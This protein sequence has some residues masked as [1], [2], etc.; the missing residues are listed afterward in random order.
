[1]DSQ[2]AGLL[3]PDLK[4]DQVRTAV[5]AD[6][7]VDIVADL[8]RA[9]TRVDPHYREVTLSCAAAAETLLAAVKA[10]GYDGVLTPLPEPHARTVIARSSL[11]PARRT[12]LIATC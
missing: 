8:S 10:Y 5:V 6:N 2:P 7:H 12:C 11:A 4:I 1:L 3:E 9:L